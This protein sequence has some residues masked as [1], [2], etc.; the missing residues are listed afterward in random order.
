MWRGRDLVALP[1]AGLRAVRGGQISMIFQEPMT[2]LNPV[3]PVRVQIEEN[4][5]AHTDLDRTAR[6]RRSRELLDLVGIPDAGRRLDEYPHQFSGGMRQRVMIAIALASD[7]SLLLADEPT[8][9]LD[10]TIQDQILNLILDLRERAGDE[11]DP[12]HPR[13]GRGGGD[14]RPHGGDVRR[15][16]R[17][18]RPGGRGLASPPMP[19]RWACW[20]RSRRPGRNARRCARS[21]ARRRA[22]PRSRPAAPSPALRLR[23][24]DLPQHAAGAGRRRIGPARRLSSQRR[25]ARRKSGRPAMSDVLLSAESVSKD[26]VFSRTIGERLTGRPRAPGPRPERRQPRGAP[27]RDAGHRRRIRLRQVHPRPLPRAAARLRR[28]PRAVRGRATSATWA[29][30]TGAPSTAVCR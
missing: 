12:R 18:G 30:A 5:R 16:H 14:L 2:A 26:F 8:T 17:R 28:R 20:A 29:A 6:K 11:R 23:L 13:P 1:E 19:T 3:L 22:W 15:P 25:G 10:V 7:P 4:L 21:R 9:A 24:R 27:G